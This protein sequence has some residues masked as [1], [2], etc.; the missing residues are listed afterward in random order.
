MNDTGTPS[1]VL[2]VSILSAHGRALKPE[3][4]AA[5]IEL[6]DVS[7]LSAHG[8]A[9]KLDPFSGEMV[10]VDVSILSAHGRALKLNL[11]SRRKSRKCR[12]NTFGS[13]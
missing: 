3:R 5:S 4:A 7:I 8:R 2:S 11:M 6:T 12:F 9:L 13:R 10:Q 1:R